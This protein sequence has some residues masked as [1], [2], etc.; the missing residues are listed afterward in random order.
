[1]VW[2]RHSLLIYVLGPA[3]T[4]IMV[5]G[6]GRTASVKGG[7]RGQLASRRKAMRA[8]DAKAVLGIA[9]NSGPPGA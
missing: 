6:Y 8:A 3:G 7:S 2:A 4:F 9:G 1:M 5:W